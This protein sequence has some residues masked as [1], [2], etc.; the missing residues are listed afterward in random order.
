[1]STTLP[2]AKQLSA[3]LRSIVPDGASDTQIRECFAAAR[4]CRTPAEVERFYAA[5]PSWESPFP[6]IPDSPKALARIRAAI[7]AG[8]RI[9]VYG[10]YDVDGVSSTTILYEFLKACGANSAAYIPHRMAEDYGLTPD[11]SANCVRE[12]SPKVIV[13]VD[14]ASTARGVIADLQAQ[15]IDVIV[16]DH[17]YP[18]ALDGHPALAHLN[19]KAWPGLNPAID[20]AMDYCAAALTF[21]FVDWLSTHLP[22]PKWDRKR[23]LFY[24]GMATVV[25]VM[26]LTRSN[27]S[28]VRQSLALA[29]RDLEEL[30]PGIARLCAVCGVDRIS[31]T[32]FGWI[33]GPHLNAAGRLEHARVAGNLLADRNAERIEGYV[34]TLFETNRARQAMQ[35]RILS[36]AH[37]QVRALL[38]QVP[39]TP[40]LVVAGKD[41]HPGVVGIVAGRLKEAY[42][43]PAFVAGWHEDGYW[44]ASGRSL[45]GC[46]LGGLVARATKEQVLLGG[47]GH[48][49]AAGIR[50]S[51]DNLESLRAWFAAQCGDTSSWV[52]YPALDTV[53]RLE[54][55]TLDGWH[56]LLSSLGPFGQGNPQPAVEF[57]GTVSG[58]VRVL[59][60]HDRGAAAGV[61]FTLNSGG[62]TY[63]VAWFGL[64]EESSSDLLAWL[65]EGPTVHGA[66]TIQCKTKGGRTFHNVTIASI[67]PA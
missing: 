8:E 64:P 18:G 30:A 65:E 22:C 24:A 5:S 1:M 28:F 25:D 26:P 29:G 47:G 67:C 6:A 31:E 4:G 48:A 39:D 63:S 34:A 51:P 58:P 50:F 57:S 20:E 44:K 43:R 13:C 37:E 27:R 59:T 16:L 62:L 10:D 61:G 42:F 9:T 40:I 66:V 56:R 14:C 46:D 15:G 7:D 41:W 35:R 33:I 38:T 52:R 60:R 45:P 12:R 32:T 55:R 36:E 3:P 19:P 49:M 54:A 11:G 17:H 53:G 2:L 23:A 21:C